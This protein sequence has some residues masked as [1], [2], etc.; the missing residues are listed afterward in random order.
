MAL[1]LGAD[2]RQALL[3]ESF[4]ISQREGEQPAYTQLYPELYVDPPQTAQYQ[5]DTV[6]LTF[7]DGPS[8]NTDTVLAVLEKYQIKATFFV[9]PAADG[10]DDERMR[11]IVQA[12][13]TIG[14]HSA[15]HDYS[16]VYQDVESFLDDFAL[17]SRLIEQATGVK[18][19]IFRFP[20]GSINQP[21]RLIFK[22]LITEM[23]RRGYT[24]F[25]WSVDGAETRGAT[26]RSI[27]LTVAD[28]MLGRERA[29]VLLHDGA[30]HEATA[31]AL[32]D[33]IL[34]LQERGYHFEPLTKNVQP[35]VFGYTLD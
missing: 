6:Y 10:S 32:E 17:A 33:I 29:I 16:A 27:Y 15:S 28:A 5:P 8:A 3:K 18:P 7:D 14:V 31:A 9:C 13:H 11:Q 4:A 34:T 24:Y 2:E 1:A 26:A 22:S 35:I 21:N 19:E 23:T 25:D 20:G 30:G 12:G